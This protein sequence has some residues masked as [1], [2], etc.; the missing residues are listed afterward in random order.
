MDKVGL[1][2]EQIVDAFN[3]VMLAQHHLIPQGH[4]LV[5]H[6]RPEPVY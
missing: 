4:G 5:F 6:F 1:V 3:D 2:L